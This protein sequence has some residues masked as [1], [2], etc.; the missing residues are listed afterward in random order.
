MGL[1]GTEAGTPVIQKPIDFRELLERVLPL[2]ELQPSDRQRIRQALG[3]A[4]SE[5]RRGERSPPSRLTE[6]E[7]RGAH[8]RRV[9]G[10]ETRRHLHQPRR[11]RRHHR[12]ASG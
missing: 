8:C 9:P 5:L 7:H 1:S 12:S 3:G 4:G 10:A 11:A 2:D 6:L